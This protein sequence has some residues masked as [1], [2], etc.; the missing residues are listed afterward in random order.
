[1]PKSTPRAKRV[2]DLIHHELANILIKEINDPRLKDFS[3][4][5]VQVSPDLKQAKVFYTTLNEKNLADIKKALLKAAGYLRRLLAG[6]T[7]LRYI[8]EL[9]FIH[10]QSIERGARISSLID[11]AIEE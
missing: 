3:L 6:S 9:R 4:T 2:A 1:M 5:T 10:D 8:P 7:E 11:K